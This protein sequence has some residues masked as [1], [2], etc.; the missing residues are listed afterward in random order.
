MN[1]MYIHVS[2]QVHKVLTNIYIF[3]KLGKFYHIVR[4]MGYGTIVCAL[5]KVYTV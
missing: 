1:Y 2:N 4:G 3:L 5:Y